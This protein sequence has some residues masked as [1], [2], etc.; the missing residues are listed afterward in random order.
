MSDADIV[1]PEVEIQGA[2]PWHYNLPVSASKILWAA[3]S[4]CIRGSSVSLSGVMS[5]MMFVY[6]MFRLHRKTA[7]YLPRLFMFP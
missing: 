3:S 7:E 5:V 2:S 1:P 6:H 4:L